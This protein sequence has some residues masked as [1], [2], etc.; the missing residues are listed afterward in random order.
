MDP[1]NDE[2]VGN[3]NEFIQDSLILKGIC[4]M[5]TNQM[6]LAAECFER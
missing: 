4:L 6:S 5:R 1:E 3:R 2:E